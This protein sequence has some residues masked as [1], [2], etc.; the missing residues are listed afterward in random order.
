MRTLKRKMAHAFEAEDFMQAQLFE[1]KTQIIA[2]VASTKRAVFAA[3]F[4][5]QWG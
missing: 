4:A 1:L 3:L 2:D 5:R